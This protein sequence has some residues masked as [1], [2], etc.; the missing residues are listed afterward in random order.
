V[1]LKQQIKISGIVSFVLVVLAVWSLSLGVFKGT[2]E[3]HYKRDRD[4]YA[5]VPW[6]FHKVGRDVFFD[7][8]EK[9]VS[10]LPDNYWLIESQS[11]RMNAIEGALLKKADL[12]Y[13]DFYQAFVVKANLRNAKL[14]GARLRE[15]DFRYAD[16]RGAN[17][18]GAD[19]RQGN[20]HRADFREA[21]LSDVKSRTVLDDQ[22]KGYQ[23]FD[24]T[25]RFFISS[26]NIINFCISWVPSPRDAAQTSRGYLWIGCSK[27]TDAAPK[28]SA[29]QMVTSR[30]TPTV[31]YFATDDAWRKS[32]P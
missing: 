24:S 20:F 22:R 7:F 27:I 31:R 16:L 2:P 3:R 19:L 8:I 1:R 28:I 17:L 14:I 23:K 21:M 4:V 26:L 11:D 25:V 12:R 30:A 6:L 9:Y 10:K 13:A 29:A 18:K 15:S 32:S 5:L